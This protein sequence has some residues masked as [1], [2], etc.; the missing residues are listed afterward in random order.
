MA[1]CFHGDGKCCTDTLK[2]KTGLNTG[3]NIN[4]KKIKVN[5]VKS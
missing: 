5:I 1:G 4:F 3:V 2:L